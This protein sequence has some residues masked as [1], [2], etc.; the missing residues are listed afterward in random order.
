MTRRPPDPVW[1]R[2]L[3]R[4]ELDAYVNAPWHPDD[5]ARAE[6]L[7]AWFRKRYPRPIDRLQY[8]TRVARSALRT[9]KKD[10]R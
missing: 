7:L 2:T 10:P 4:E 5:R 3:T 6:E 8:A 9:A 1:D